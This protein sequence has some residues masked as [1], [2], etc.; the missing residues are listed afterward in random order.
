MFVRV[1]ST[2]ASK[3][4]NIHKNNMLNLCIVLCN[5]CEFTF[6]LNEL[7]FSPT[8]EAGFEVPSV[9]NSIYVCRHTYI[10]KTETAW[11]QEY[12]QI[13]LQNA[14]VSLNS[15]RSARVSFVR[16]IV[17][18]ISPSNFKCDEWISSEIVQT[19]T[20]P[21]ELLN[22]KF[23]DFIKQD[24]NHLSP[25]F[26]ELMTDLDSNEQLQTFTRNFFWFKVNKDDEN[27]DE[28]RVLRSN[29]KRNPSLE[30]E[31]LSEKKKKKGKTGRSNMLS[32]LDA[33]NLAV[34]MGDLSQSINIG[35]LF[36]KMFE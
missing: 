13:A 10:P 17:E 26:D 28:L 32:G 30:S 29:T 21:K 20:D 22:A 24:L 1:D 3:T 27:N 33:P 15:L 25:F 19:M 23:V 12:L 7:E 34:E 16:C 11:I 14:S 36:N 35:D 8:I 2:N 4:L 18:A 6:E 5:E 31:I 9:S